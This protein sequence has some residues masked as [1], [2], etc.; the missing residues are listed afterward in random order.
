MKGY[1]LKI[2]DLT[3]RD[4]FSD[5]LQSNDNFGVVKYM[6]HEEKNDFEG[7]TVPVIMDH[8]YNIHWSEGFAFR[9]VDLSTNVQWE[10]GKSID[11]RFNVTNANELYD[12]HYS[13]FDNTN[14]NVTEVLIPHSA[15][16]LPSSTTFGESNYNK[17]EGKLSVHIGD[18][19]GHVSIQEVSCR[20]T[21]QEEEPEVEDEDEFRYWSKL[22][23]WQLEVEGDEEVV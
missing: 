19:R 18:Q 2:F 8:F 15:A 7:W 1:D 4:D 23:D 3:T 22:A 14:A 11:V 13:G 6:E 9:N 16:S 17:E 12:I 5:D 20:D 21:C 10:L